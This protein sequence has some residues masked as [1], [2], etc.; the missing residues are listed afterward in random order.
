MSPFPA[1][2][3]NTASSGSMSGKWVAPVQPTP[4]PDTGGEVELAEHI[5][6]GLTNDWELVAFIREELA[7]PWRDALC[8]ARAVLAAGYVSPVTLADRLAEAIKAE[9]EL[10]AAEQ[11]RIY[12]VIWNQGWK[13][14]VVSPYTAPMEGDNPYRA[15]RTAP[16][17]DAEEVGE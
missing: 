12:E 5:L 17:Q 4:E 13:A 3:L 8:Q 6:H 16:L 1:E 7:Q 9:R 2:P 15:A 10:I 14:A 11:E